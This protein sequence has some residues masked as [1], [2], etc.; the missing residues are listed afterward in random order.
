MATRKYKPLPPHSNSAYPLTHLGEVNKTLVVGIVAILAIIALVILLFFA[1]KFVGKA[2]E[3]IPTRNIPPNSAGVFLVPGS[4]TFNV[5]EN[6]LLLPVYANIENKKT[7]AIGFKMVLPI[8]FPCPKV[9]DT[10]DFDDSTSFIENNCLDDNIGGKVINF[11]EATLDPFLAHSST[12]RIV[13]IQ[14]DAETGFP[15]VGIHR[16]DFSSFIVDLDTEQQMV[17]TDTSPTI[18]VQDLCADFSCNDHGICSVIDNAP[19]CICDGT[20]T[21]THCAETVTCDVGE[22][23]CTDGTHRA[24]C[25]D[26][27]TAYDLNPE[28]CAATDNICNPA[29]N[30]CVPPPPTNICQ[31][32]GQECDAGGNG[33]ICLPSGG[34]GRFCVTPACDNAL[35][36][37]T[38]SV[39]VSED[40]T[41]EES[42]I[43]F[44][45]KCI[46]IDTKNELLNSCQGLPFYCMYKLLLTA[47]QCIAGEGGCSNDDDLG[48]QCSLGLS[49]SGNNPLYDASINVCLPAL[50]TNDDYELGAYGAC[51]LNGNDI[52]CGIGTQTAS[53]QLR[54]GDRCQGGV[55]PETATIDNTQDC[56]LGNDACVAPDT[57]C[58]P[59]GQCVSPDAPICAEEHFTIGAWDVCNVQCGVGGI[60][61]RSVTNIIACQGGVVP[62]STRPCDPVPQCAVGNNCVANQCVLP[63]QICVPGVTRCSGSANIETCNADG[64]AW[65]TTPCAT[66]KC[67]DTKC[68]L[69][70]SVG[71]RIR[72]DELQPDGNVYNTLVTALAAIPED[73]KIFT[74][75]YTTGGPILIFESRL[76]DGLANVGNTIV[77]STDSAGKDVVRKKV[78]IW[79]TFNLTI[80]ELTL[81]HPLEYSYI[82]D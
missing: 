57:I 48:V 14:F 50:C 41:C 66:G 53:I 1:Q 32:I 26:A 59:V 40:G 67:Y 36:A 39:D 33:L 76:V 47:E 27:R 11:W 81:N 64:L 74:T 77:V 29:T 5:G 43:P 42:T 51:Q 73:F 17:L 45:S 70:F 6:Y 63:G 60:Q 30:T 71:P 18:I 56:D 68:T 61:T 7:V 23:S 12:F 54:T 79:D 62:S 15:P 52:Q 28:D 8:G 55:T 22:W 46:T 69:A 20:F 25:N 9:V 24:Q 3:Y 38:G 82:P 44:I 35:T 21:G 58:N 34:M 13:T 16:L 2:F 78:V 10:L 37:L 31:K 4:N 19:Q 80:Q 49:C 65:T 75:L 72:A